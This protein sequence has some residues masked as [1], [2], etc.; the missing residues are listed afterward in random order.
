MGKA[1][2]G[3]KIL[4]FTHVQS[5]PTCTQLLAWFGADVIKVERAGREV[6]DQ[7]VAGLDQAVE[8]LLALGVLGVQRDRALVVVQHREIEAVH[9]RDVAQLAARDVAFAGALDLDH[10]GAEP[11]EQLR[12]CRTRLHVREIENPNPV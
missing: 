8:N 3:V 12:A 4:D 7:H 5:G 2:D 6:L 10:V 1:L 11:G 9:V